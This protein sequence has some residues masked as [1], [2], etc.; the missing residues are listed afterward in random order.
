MS[1]WDAL[2]G[3]SFWVEWA[4]RP[5]LDLTLDWIEEV[6][7]A[8]AVHVFDLGCGVGRHAVCLAERDMSVVAS[9]ISP[10]AV[11]A[12]RQSLASR[13]LRGFVVRAGMEPLPFRNTSFDAALSIGV[14]EHNTRKGIERAIAEIARCLRPG[15]RALASFVPRNRWIPKDEPGSDLIEDNT[16]RSY[17]P[18]ESIHHLVDE[19]ELRELFR[20]FTIH[21]IE[22]VTE[23]FERGCCG[24][25]LVSAEKPANGASGS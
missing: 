24:E 17:G 16:L 6:R 15:G 9:D 5:P 4:Q 8:G 23:T 25:L 13:G 14:L 22:G 1:G 3:E 7:A 20:G 10:R 11:E 12:T 21:S 19:A 2:F 18:E